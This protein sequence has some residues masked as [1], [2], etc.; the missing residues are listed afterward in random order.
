MPMPGDAVSLAIT[1]RSRFSCR[2]ISSISALRRS[3]AHEAAD[4]QA[5]PVRDQ[6][7]CLIK[8][9]RLH[10]ELRLQYGSQL[11]RIDWIGD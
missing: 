1:V 10:P 9:D 3:D 5:R 8:R 7:H 2:T 4:H 11:Q 6:S